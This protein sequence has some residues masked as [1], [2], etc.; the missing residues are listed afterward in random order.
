MTSNPGPKR[1]PTLRVSIISTFILLIL[2]SFSSITGLIYYYTNQGLTNMVEDLTEKVATRVEIETLNH[3]TGAINEISFFSELFS[4]GVLKSTDFQTIETLFLKRL[5]EHN[6]IE[7]LNLGLTDGSFIM[8]KKM[9]SGS[10]DTKLIIGTDTIWHRRKPDSNKIV[11]VEKSK[12]DGYDPR[13]RPW[14]KGAVNS[15]EYYWT[16]VYIFFADKK[17]GVTVGRKITVNGN[18]VGVVSADIG[19]EQLSRFVSTMKVSKKGEVFIVDGNNRIVGSPAKITQRKNFKFLSDLASLEGS[20][21]ISVQKK[22]SSGITPGKTVTFKSEGKEFS[23]LSIDLK[24]PEGKNWRVLILVPS[25]DFLS[26]LITMTKKALILIV[27]LFIIALVTG[28]WVTHRMSK[29]LKL[30]VSEVEKIRNF[31]FSQGNSTLHTSFQEIE[32]VMVSVEN[33]KVGLRALEKYVP[34]DLVKVL[35]AQN[36]DPSLGGEIKNLTIFF[37]DIEGF[38]GFSEQCSPDQLTE[39][40]ADYL[41]VMSSTI[42]Y[43]QGTV[44]KYIGDAVM[45]FWGAPVEVE[46]PSYLACLSALECQ[47]GITELT[48]KFPERPVFRTRIGIDCGNVLVGN[49]GSNNR[50]NYTVIGDHVN[51]AS[52]LEGINKIYGTSIIISDDVKESVGNLLITRKLDMVT[53]KGKQKPVVLYELL[54]KAEDFE[55]TEILEKV[56]IYEE[57]F[58]LYLKK[59]FISAGR[60]FSE[61]SRKFPEDTTFTLFQTRCDD[62]L[63]NPPDNNWNGVYNIKTK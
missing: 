13:K 5:T 61:G 34:K 40:L 31:D 21:Y 46:N 11:S 28:I 1:K 49:I 18:L 24:Y 54:G 63:K 19:L 26:R 27:F 15:V 60:L 12:N 55:D 50:Y 43:H 14:Y 8:V 29:P 45:A 22:I 59:D 32:N 47:Q 4:R 42:R 52:R 53:V 23:L 58:E 2:F 7:M 10:F 25:S 37:S 3:F 44:D 38:T 51:Q 41:D 48:E 57:A 9:P 30:L 62:F 6:E 56:K 17:P 35:L 36:V 39:F 33:M 16:D 20:E